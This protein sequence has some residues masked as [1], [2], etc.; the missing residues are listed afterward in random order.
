MKT[1]SFIGS[2]KNAGKTTA[3]NFVLKKLSEQNKELIITSI[4]ING[5]GTDQFIGRKKPFIKIYQNNLFITAKEHIKSVQGLISVLDVYSPP[6]FSKVFVLC[7]A[8]TSFDIVLEG[9]NSKLEIL[10]LKNKLEINFLNFELLI[11]GSIDRQFLGDPQISDKIYFSLLL[12]SHKEQQLKVSNYITALKLP[13]YQNELKTSDN[14]FKS[15]LLNSSG[16]VVYTSDT[17]AFLDE[18]LIDKIK[19]SKDE[20]VL[21]LKSALID[22]L[23]YKLKPYKKLK[24]VLENFTLLRY[25]KNYGLDLYL[26]NKTPDV[27]FFYKYDDLSSKLILPPGIDIYRKDLH[28]VRV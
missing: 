28:E 1:S 12:N 8:L 16:E 22:S 10:N 23:A 18:A 2:N 13:V 17:L 14:N 26:L 4:G 11:D 21:V 20:Q 6:T 27:D 25:E 15:L 19:L 9:P 7:R 3:L 24:I 5:E